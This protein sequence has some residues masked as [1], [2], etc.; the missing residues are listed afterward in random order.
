MASIKDYVAKADEAD[1]QKPEI[2]QEKLKET[3]DNY[4]DL[5][6]LFLSKYGNMSEDELIAEMLKLINQKKQE[7]TYNPEELKMLASRVKPFLN[8][9]QTEKMEDLLKYL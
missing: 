7:G 6:E 3:Q 5:I 4:S 8:A 2:T 9:E 1:S